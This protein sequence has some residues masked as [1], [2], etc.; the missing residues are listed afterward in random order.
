M[1]RNSRGGKGAGP[2][3]KRAVGI[4]EAGERRVGRGIPK[5]AGNGRNKE[6][7]ATLRIK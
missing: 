7:I 3:T 6:K 1:Q 2:E 5:V 4:Q